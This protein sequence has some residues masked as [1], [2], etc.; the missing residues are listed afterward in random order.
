MLTLY[1]KDNCRF[2]KKALAAL[3]EVGVSCE[4]K[5]IKD[6]AV[7]TELIEKGGKKQVPFLDDAD[8]CTS[9]GHITPC[10]VHD[11]VMMYESEDIADYLRKNYG[12]GG[13]L[14]KHGDH[15]HVIEGGETCESK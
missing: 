4:V 15:F 3:E 9:A 12:K 10:L 14:V 5:N 11:E 8:P 6:P 13:S 7:A 2:S 1:I